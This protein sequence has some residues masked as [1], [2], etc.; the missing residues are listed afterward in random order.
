MAEIPVTE[1]R[2]VLQ[3]SGNRCAFSGCGIL[4][5]TP[6]TEHD[7]L[8]SIGQIAHI[9]G[10]SPDGPRGDSPLTREE[11]D[12]YENVLLLCDTHHD[13][14]D[15]QPATFT[16]ER[17]HQMKADHEAFVEKQLDPAKA[18]A[19]FAHA[20]T[21][22]YGILGRAEYLTVLLRSSDQRM[23]DRRIGAG[24]ST[25]QAHRSLRLQPGIPESLTGLPAG[26]ARLLVGPLGSGKS[27]IAEQWHRANV[28]AA[29]TADTRPIPLWLNPESLDRSLE[30]QVFDEIGLTALAGIG[31]DIVIDGLD[32]HTDRSASA[33]RQ[34]RE[35]VTKWGKSRVVLTSRSMDGVPIPTVDAPPLDTDQSRRLMA[36]VAGHEIGAL[37]ERIEEAVRRPL[38]ALL[39][40]VH[41]SGD[42]GATGIPDLVDRV[43]DTVVAAGG[44]DLY[45]EL[46][47][48]AVETIRT[49]KPVDPERFTTAD[50][51]TRIRQSSLVTRIGRTCTFSLATFTQWFAAKAVAEGVVDVPAELTSLEA[52][53]RWKYVLAIV[54]A[55]GEPEKADAVMAPLARWNP[56][57]ASWVIRE[58]HAG[59]L[60][61][62]RPDYTADDWMAVGER[63][64]VAAEAWLV[65]L[66]PLAGATFPVRFSGT[67]DLAEI[68]LAV[69]LDPPHRLRLAWLL[70]NEIPGEP[71]DA[72]ERARNLGQR[73]MTLRGYPITVT[74]PNWVWE[75]IRDLLAGDISAEGLAAIVL[76]VGRNH[77]SV[78]GQEQRAQLKRTIPVELWGPI[79][80]E[81]VE[82][83]E[84]SYPSPD[85]AA[86][87]A[88]PWGGY[89]P[90]TMI[91]R[92]RAIAAAAMTCYLELSEILT[93]NF[94]DTLGV[95][96]LMPVEFYGDVSYHPDRERST[97]GFPGPTE[98]G[99]AWLLRPLAQDPEDRDVT[100]NVVSLTLNDEARREELQ[101]GYETFSSWHFERVKARP[102]YEPFAPNFSL[103]TGRSRLS[104]DLPATRFAA[105]WLWQDLKRLGW[106]TGSYA[107][108]L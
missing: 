66:G 50:I 77:P 95:R 10:Q 33:I 62:H 71:L 53:D 67:T 16:V 29:Q 51:A 65:G 13:I 74:G 23:H 60:R 18:A 11:R 6:E 89:T 5:T 24:L 105:E 90:E 39:V 99:L 102:E 96:G 87:Y 32:E 47:R 37:D 75:M 83:T 41:A 97:F 3:R 45:V 46:Q 100:A 73:T 19:P 76:R 22:P 68:T 85:I 72:V 84:S 36:V 43:V 7:R 54:L 27:D 55:A 78:V 57:A 44:H 49:G 93:P 38:F 8:A 94:G 2:K 14:V 79:A 28:A 103:H 4:L 69:E 9:V 101:D 92:A 58:T 15:K 56:G 88:A 26:G 12:R 64:R 91:E 25:E 59:G 48:L 82:A 42:E 30:Q 20:P 17:L 61:R 63:M 70:R 81:L 98:P 40:A 34:A 52:F 35:L 1:R 107:P 104:G 80:G 21:T 86:S 108:Q 31:V 106:A